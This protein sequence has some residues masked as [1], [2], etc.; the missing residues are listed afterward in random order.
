MWLRPTSVSQSKLRPSDAAALSI[1]SRLQNSRLILFGLLTVVFV[2]VNP[3]VTFLRID[4]ELVIPE[5][6]VNKCIDEGPGQ[7][8]PSRVNIC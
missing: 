4:H 7:I 1:P 8:P 3:A 2:L 5:A 6:C